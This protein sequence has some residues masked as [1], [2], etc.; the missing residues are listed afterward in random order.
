MRRAIWFGVLISCAG[1]RAE[2]ISARCRLVPPPPDGGALA[3]CVAVGPEAGT[4]GAKSP[5][6]AAAVERCLTAL[7]E[8]VPRSELA[9]V[10]GIARR[11]TFVQAPA[12]AQPWQPDHGLLAALAR[13][14]ALGADHP[15]MAVARRLAHH[16]QLVDELLRLL[17]NDIDCERW[18]VL[19][20][21]LERVDDE[22]LRSILFDYVHLLFGAE[23]RERAANLQRILVG[24]GDPSRGQESTLAETRAA[25]AIALGATRDQIKQLACLD[26]HAAK[27]L[28]LSAR[29]FERDLD[30]H[31]RRTLAYR[32]AHTLCFAAGQRRQIDADERALRSGQRAELAKR[33]SIEPRDVEAALAEMKR[34]ANQLGGIERGYREATGEA[35]SPQLCKALAF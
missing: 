24:L 28:D 12:P 15:L 5:L 34:V 27:S 30:E 23:A 29:T 10:Q 25:L 3:A 26:P 13:L 7:A 17:E 2:T 16:Y 22:T 4:C 1:P 18:K 32:A 19:E 9:M 31:A 35:F 14:E 33:W 11:H 6:R 8:E 21:A 20:A